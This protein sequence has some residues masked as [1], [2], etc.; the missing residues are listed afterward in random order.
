MKI[1]RMVEE[2]IKEKLE[3]D[4]LGRLIIANP[5]LLD[6]ISG[7][8]LYD[9]TLHNPQDGGCNGGCSNDSC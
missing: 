6:T 8:A 2:L 9:P 3:L 5:A 1:S 7:A 4:E